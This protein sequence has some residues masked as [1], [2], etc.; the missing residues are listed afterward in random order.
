MVS[1][2]D[3]RVAL[4]LF[5]TGR[6][7]SLL[8]A[9]R[10]TPP[11]LHIRPQEQK[12]ACLVILDVHQLFSNTLKAFDERTYAVDQILGVWRAQ[13]RNTL[14]CMRHT[15]RNFVNGKLQIREM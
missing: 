1:D 11:Y 10:L 12:T 6:G 3:T 8:A 9:A 2:S 13:A 15:A 4:Q 7:M 5:P 14:S